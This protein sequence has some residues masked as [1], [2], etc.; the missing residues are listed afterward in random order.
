MTEYRIG[1]TGPFPRTEELVQATRDLDRG[2]ISPA[3]AE[4]AFA[5]AEA[6]VADV[7]ERL[8]FDVR[9]GGYLRWADMF[10]PFTETWPGVEAGA[11][12]RFFETNTFYRQPV[13]RAR[14]EG[15]TGRLATW[16]PDSPDHLA[17]L[18]GP[19]TFAAL[20]ER[21]YAPAG[22]LTPVEEIAAAMTAELRSLGPRTPRQI[23]FQ[24]PMLTY[25]PPRG[26]GAEIVRAYRRLA[27]GLPGATISVWTYFGDVRPVLPLLDRLPV[28]RIGFDLFESSL[29]GATALHGKGIGAGVIDSRSTLAEEPREVA[30]RVKEA[31]RTLGATEVFLG[32]T[33]PLDR[34]PFAPAVEK[35]ALLPALR[36]EIAR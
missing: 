10:R 9:T 5:R 2:R 26:D 24:E 18:P 13:L 17:I 28:A 20:A 16:L 3:A 1:A 23:Q 14:P 4:A 30:R 19:F 11:L 6:E 29:E 34:L 15:G 32:P 33:P 21:S 7:E 25:R 22:P 27:E 8:G 36:T 35:L 31:V 12:T